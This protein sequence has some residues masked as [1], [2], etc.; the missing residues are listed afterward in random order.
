MAL[1]EKAA[2]GMGRLGLAELRYL[3]GF[4]TRLPGGPGAP[5]PA[6]NPAGPAGPRQAAPAG[7]AVLP[8]VVP[9]ISE[10]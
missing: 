1:D 7:P 2:D 3:F 6:L 9:E 10:L 8:N 5:V 4:D